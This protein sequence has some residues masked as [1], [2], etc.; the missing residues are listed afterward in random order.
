[1]KTEWLHE[2]RSATGQRFR[3]GR[4]GEI[5]IAEWDDLLRLEVDA[6]GVS[7]VAA[8]EETLGVRKLRAGAVPA[9]VG[10]LTG[11]L[12]WHAA[13]CCWPAS[14]AVMVLGDA[15]AGK[16][17]LV[18]G[19]CNEGAASFLADDIAHVKA[20]ETGWEA[21]RCEE[22]HAMRPDM[23]SALFGHAGRDKAVFA[24]TRIRRRAPLG[25]I[26]GL[27]IGDDFALRAVPARQKVQLLTRNLVRFALDD[28]Q[29][30]RRDLDVVLRLAA[31]VPVYSLVRPRVFTDWAGLA[32][33]LRPRLRG[34]LR[35]T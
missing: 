25:M 29:L 10:H 23:A 30:L 5:R 16:S 35:A 34:V 28:P 33:L 9:L 20:T 4:S 24:P 1:M 12:H 8:A 31:E 18:A 11:H 14:S 22:N 13:A 7:T 17:T 6:A 26:L 21:W 19:L 27:E 15:G 3:I 32:D 2:V